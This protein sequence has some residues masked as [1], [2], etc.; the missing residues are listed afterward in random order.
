MFCD[1]LD[2]SEIQKR[3][4][5]GRVIEFEKPAVVMLTGSRGRRDIV[6]AAGLDWVLLKNN[7]DEDAVKE[8]ESLINSVEKAVEYCKGLAE[9]KLKA[10]KDYFV[11]AAVICADTVV[12][13]KRLL[14]KPKT[15][16]EVYEMI[17]GL[18]GSK[19]Q[20]I[21][22]VSIYDCREHPVCPDGN[23]LRQPP[24]SREGNI[25]T[26]ASESEVLL[27]G[28]TDGLIAE[29]IRLENPYACSGGYTID[30]ILGPHFKVLAGTKDNVIGLP[31]KEILMALQ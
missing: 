25:L 1:K 9:Q 29:M 21:T 6:K 3:L 28:V 16:A 19:H 31:L 18:N 15:E 20:V 12:F 17:R 13:N 5:A 8:D 11:N 30:G 22:G 24:L 2:I 23:R 10:V 27:S 14:E 4:D 7:F 26:F